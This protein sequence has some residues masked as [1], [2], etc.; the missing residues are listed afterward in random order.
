M[1]RFE[2]KSEAISAAIK[3]SSENNKMHQQQ[4]IS[5]ENDN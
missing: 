1:T 4:Y 3:T 2:A 5:I